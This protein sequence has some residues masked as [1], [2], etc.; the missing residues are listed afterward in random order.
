MNAMPA[1]AAAGARPRLSAIRI[2][3]MNLGFLGLQFSFGLQQ[4]NMGPIYSYLGANEASLPLLQLAGP[5]TG[6]L[7]Q[8]LV[9]A[10]SDRTA[11][12]L[13][14]R[15]P[16]FILGA[17]MCSIGLFLMPLSS[18]LLMAVSL[19]WIIDAGN[20]MTMDPYRAYVKDRLNPDQQPLGFLSQSAFTGLA[21]TLAFLTPSLLVHGFGMDGN[22]LD[23][24]NIPHITRIAFTIGA[25]LSL[26]TI[27]W[28]IWRV[29]E[30]P[31][32]DDERAR[33]AALPKSVGATLG[34][35]GA[36]IRDMPAGM[37]RLAW[38][39]LFQ[40]YGMTC[41]WAYVTY[42]IS[43]TVHG[44][45]DPLSSA[46]R[47]AVLTNGQV[48]AFYNAVACVAAFGLAALSRRHR[49]ARLHAL[50][51]LASG[52]GMLVI[53]HVGEKTLLFLP[54]IGIGLGWAS[55]MGLPHAMLAATIPP[56][57]TGVYMGIF[58]LF[59]VIPMLLF[60]VTM[61]LAYDSLL[62]GDARNAISLSGALML[63][64]ALLVPRTPRSAAPHRG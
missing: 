50:C 35:I 54:A 18:S 8:P 52:L 4:A 17:L 53:P 42:S 41:Y 6:L 13:G 61:P 2:L 5:V 46:F 15:T 48:G 57:R 49:P 45:S 1:C 59:I 31:L 34:E 20:N 37:R 11:S 25:V 40:W 51:L 23:N 43:R 64:A 39:S 63:T 14:R 38:M 28:S 30:L 10:M 9:G 29:P 36:A 33:I 44:T 62:G 24:H 60:A 26:V 16:Y 27:L 55:M 56:E 22:A 3:Q 12:R 32:T 7:V 58:N 21:Q 47:D 19:L